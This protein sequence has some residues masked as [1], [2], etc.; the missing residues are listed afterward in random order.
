M[1]EISLH[2]LDIA[3]NSVTANASLVEITVDENISADKLTVV[4]KDNGKGMSEELLAKVVDPFTTGRKTRKVGLGIPLIKM[5]AEVTGG[6]FSLES[7]LGVGT[8]LTAVF[9]YS[10]IDRQPLGNMAETMLGMVTSYEKVDFL[11]THKVNDKEF[12]LDTREIKKVLGDVSLA[13][14]DVYM[15]LSE[16]LKEGE[17]ELLN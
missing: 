11:Y 7:E 9:K 8:T 2:I 14:P 10:S 15:W 1:R 16:Y 3:Q 4:I 5:A 6:S 13:V 17:A 12:V